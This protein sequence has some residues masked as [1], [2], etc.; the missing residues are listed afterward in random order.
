VLGDQDLAT[1]ILRSE[2]LR[3]GVPLS[4]VIAEFAAALS[5]QTTILPMTDD[6]VATVVSTPSGR[7]EFQ[8][9][10]VHRHQEDDVLGV[11]FD[12]APKA[13]PAN[14]VLEA[15]AGAELIVICPSNP[16]V[17][18]GPILAVPGIFDALKASS[19]PII[20]VSPI[21]GGKALK[22]PADKMLATLGHEVSAKGVAAIYDGLIDGIVIDLQDAELADSISTLGQRVL[23]AQTI[24]GDADDRRR[25]AAAV[26]EFGR[27]L[28]PAGS[29]AT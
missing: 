17:S 12:G 8:E 13:M 28:V 26:L 1:H 6:P 20:A 23:V 15:I 5:V 2:R 18:I 11:E 22:G 27:S 3:A 24:M 21:V 25:L 4:K 19:A 9:Y 29:V 16:I 10:F 14:G 7:L